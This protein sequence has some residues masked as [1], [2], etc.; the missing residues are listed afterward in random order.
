MVGQLHVIKDIIMKMPS[1]HEK[2]YALWHARWHYSPMLMLKKW[3]GEHLWWCIKSSGLTH[4]EMHQNSDSII[5]LGL[6]LNFINSRQ[7]LSK[8]WKSARFSSQTT[9]GSKNLGTSGLSVEGPWSAGELDL[10]SSE[11]GWNTFFYKNQ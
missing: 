8:Q 3:A 4:A 10:K 5:I 1:I 9:R 7:L 11:S 2:T 6:L